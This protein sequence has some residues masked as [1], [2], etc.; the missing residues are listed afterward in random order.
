MEMDHYYLPGNVTTTGNVT[1]P[2]S[3]VNTGNITTLAAPSSGSGSLLVT[4]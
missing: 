2:G 4:R 1:A 3:V